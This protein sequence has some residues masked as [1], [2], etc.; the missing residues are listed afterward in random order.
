MEFSKT[1]RIRAYMDGKTCKRTIQAL[2]ISHLDYANGLLVV[3]P[4]NTPINCRWFRKE[5]LKLSWEGQNKIALRK[6]E[7]IYTGYL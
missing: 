2:V 6:P 7:L 1:K 3:V 4:K 5:L